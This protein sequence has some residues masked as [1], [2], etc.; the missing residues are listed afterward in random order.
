MTK[1][2]LR[3]IRKQLGLTQKEFGEKIGLSGRHVRHLEA[4]GSAIR[5]TLELLVKQLE[6]LAKLSDSFSFELVK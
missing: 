4:G 5:P 3:N 2:E 6:T 1:E